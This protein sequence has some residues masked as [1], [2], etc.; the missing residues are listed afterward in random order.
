MHD[1]KNLSSA[2][3]LSRQ[4]H[5]VSN[6]MQRHRF[7]FKKEQGR[8][9]DHSSDTRGA[10]S[11]RGHHHGLDKTVPH[12]QGRLLRLLKETDGLPLKDIVEALDIRPSSASELV[13]KLEQNGYVSRTTNAE[14]KRVVNVF[15]TPAGLARIAEKISERKQRLDNLYA[16]LDE[17]EQKQLSALLGKLISSLKENL[18]EGPAVS[19]NAE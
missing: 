15:I 4:F 1:E 6:L 3:T 10:E 11:H 5:K 19:E 12:G 2:E 8:P 16:A 9:I 17:Q 14:D 13:A 18:G 7:A